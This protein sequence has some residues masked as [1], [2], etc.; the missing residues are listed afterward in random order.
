MRAGAGALA[1]DRQQG[2]RGK[3]VFFLEAANCKT[4]KSSFWH[5]KLNRQHLQ[6]EPATEI[7]PTGL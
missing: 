2:G 1:W 3:K 7:K 5:K 6:G 4:G